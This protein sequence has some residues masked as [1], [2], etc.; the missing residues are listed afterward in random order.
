MADRPEIE[1]LIAFHDAQSEYLASCDLTY[2]SDKH[3][4]TTTALRS[5]LEEV[6]RLRGV[7]QPAVPERVAVAVARMEA[8][9][10]AYEPGNYALCDGV[11]HVYA[12]VPECCQTLRDDLRL[13]IRALLAALSSPPAETWQPIETAPRDGSKVIAFVP[14]PGIGETLLIFDDG[15][16]R[17]PVNHLVLRHEP[18]AW[19]PLPTPPKDEAR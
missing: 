8:L 12:N 19:L 10:D 9:A 14:H 4:D 1:E 3:R 17:E 5:L 15:H 7:T 18:T 2:G 11:Y 6:E 16:W 13:G